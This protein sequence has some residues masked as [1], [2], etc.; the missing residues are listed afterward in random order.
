MQVKHCH[1]CSCI[2][3]MCLRSGQDCQPLVKGFSF[4]LCADCGQARANE[5]CITSEEECRRGCAIFREKR[6][7]LA[8]VT[9]TGAGLATAVGTAATVGGAAAYAT[10][11]LVG[12]AIRVHDWWTKNSDDEEEKKKP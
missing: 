4:D 10:Y 8:G 9:I 12:T 7:V 1:I 3:E 6:L 2:S 5:S 11:H